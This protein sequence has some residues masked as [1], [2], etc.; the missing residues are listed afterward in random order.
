MS[1]KRDELQHDIIETIAEQKTEHAKVQDLEN[2]IDAAKQELPTHAEIVRLSDEFGAA[3][4]AHG[5]E[6][7][8]SKEINDLKESKSRAEQRDK[9]LKAQL[10]QLLLQW[11]T[12]T[13]ERS[14][15]LGPDMYEI[16]LN[17]SIGKKLDRQEP[18]PL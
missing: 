13:Q 7:Q 1:K 9:E 12:E 14:I 4:A 15:I 11:T 8:N 18:L 2:R 17:A 5:Q 16:K 6:V 10:K 3:R